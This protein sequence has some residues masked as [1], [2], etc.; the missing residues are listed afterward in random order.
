MAIPN[1]LCIQYDRHESY[2][3]LQKIEQCRGQGWSFGT[4]DPKGTITL[5]KDLNDALQ[6]GELPDTIKQINEISAMIC[7]QERASPPQ[8]PPRR[9]KPQL[10]RLSE[11]TEP[12]TFEAFKQYD[13]IN[14]I[15]SPQFSAGFITGL[16]L[17]QEQYL[18]LS[19]ELQAE[20]QHL[21]E[22]ISLFDRIIDLPSSNSEET[23]RKKVSF[24]NLIDI[25]NR[26]YGL[27]TN[28][29]KYLL[30]GPNIVSDI[31][32]ATRKQKLISIIM[33]KKIYEEEIKITIKNNLNS[34][35]KE[36]FPSIT[37]S[38]NI[39]FTK[40]S[41][42][43]PIETHNQGKSPCIIRF[44]N[45]TTELGKLVCKARSAEAEHALMQLF[46]KINLAKKSHNQVLH[47]CRILQIGENMSMW[48]FVDGTPLPK[49][50]VNQEGPLP[51]KN[52][53]LNHKF[54]SRNK[55]TKAGKE[56]LISQLD[57]I[58]TIANKIKIGDLNYENFLIINISSDNPK[59]VLIDGEN[60]Q[61]LKSFTT[62]IGGNRDRF[63]TTEIEELLDNFNKDQAHNLHWRVI[64][65]D[66]QVLFNLYNNATE[67]VELLKELTKFLSDDFQLS[68]D[69]QELM[70]LLI[71]DYLNGDIPYFTEYQ[72]I[73]YHGGVRSDGRLGKEI[74]RR[75]GPT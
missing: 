31:N 48:E 21:L 29:L 40:E 1:Y 64:L 13:R 3:A 72:G 56:N 37:D 5:Y 34:I 52:S 4:M 6:N 47:T 38:K 26:K 22:G 35:C 51:L 74:A 62:E 11:K 60:R 8:V 28:P 10:I 53:I 27:D 50:L 68:V 42:P 24:I 33:N 44:W 71:L 36:F 32:Y 57:W 59:L 70:N 43:G 18:N 58:D 46:K 66:S 75:K 23:E 16:K 39:T 2:K 49:P 41:F 12:K 15:N 19:T 17:C 45:G 61:N 7:Q 25:F 69:N 9:M 63:S 30:F 65:A 73:M 54:I 14:F 55:I 67:I 20:Y